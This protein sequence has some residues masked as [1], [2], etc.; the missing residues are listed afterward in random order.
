MQ[1]CKVEEWILVGEARTLIQ[2]LEVGAEERVSNDS[3]VEHGLMFDR[4]PHRPPSQTAE[5]WSMI[6]EVLADSFI[7]TE[8]VPPTSLNP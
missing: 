4:S 8:H 2:V 1:Q 3:F 7:G 6:R 5:K